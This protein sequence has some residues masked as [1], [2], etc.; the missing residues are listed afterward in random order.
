M[1]RA[2]VVAV[3]AG[4]LVGLAAHAAV[5]PYDFTGPWTGTARTPR[6]PPVMLSADLTTTTPPEFAGTLTIVTT[7]ETIH[8]TVSGRQRR[9]VGMAAPCDNMGHLRLKGSLNRARGTLSGRMVWMPPP[10]MH[11]PPKH[12]SVPPAHPGPRARPARIR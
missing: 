3:L 2:S 10:D 5:V 9:R 7:E 8:C 6:K 11:K 1:M 4:S 12:G